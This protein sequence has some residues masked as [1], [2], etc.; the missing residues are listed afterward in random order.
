MAHHHDGRLIFDTT[1]D[2][3]GFNKGISALKSSAKFA[4]KAVAVSMLVA[5]AAIA[6]IGIYSTKASIEFESAF[7]GVRKTVEGTEADFKMLERG[8][9]EMSK[10]MPQTAAEI[11]K[12]SEAAGQLGIKTDAILGF[13]ET[14]IM[15]GDTTNLSSEQAATALAR[16]ANITGMS[17]D[18]FDK[19]GST[20]VDLGKDCCPVT[21]KQVA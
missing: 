10:K 4:A 6:G 5:S 11:A 13:T 2:Q 12:V 9:I 15:L 14:M 18:D 19:L 7:A 21:W 3:K 17:Q 16:L 1:V 20:I 8:I